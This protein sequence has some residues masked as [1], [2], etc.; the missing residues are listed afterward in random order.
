MA[1][2]QST[3]VSTRRHLHPPSWRRVPNGSRTQGCRRVHAHLDVARC[4]SRSD[5]GPLASTYGLSVGSLVQASSLLVKQQSS[6]HR[7]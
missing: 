3:G 1:I 7:P 2:T 4:K 6:F 5:P